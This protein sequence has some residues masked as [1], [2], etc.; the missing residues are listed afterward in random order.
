VLHALVVEDD[1]ELRALVREFLEE[2]GYRVVTAGDA[3]EALGIAVRY[4]PTVILLDRGL[5]RWSGESFAR[6]YLSLPG[7]LAPVVLITAAATLPAELGALPG[8]VGV[9][10]KPLALDTLL[11]VAQRHAGPPT[12]P[13]TPATPGGL[14]AA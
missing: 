3:Y 4:C 14:G 6:L 2:E 1:P 13:A 9:V 10:E 8:L 7:P 12:A 5:P 11:A